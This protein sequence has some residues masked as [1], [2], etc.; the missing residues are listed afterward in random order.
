[1][2]MNLTFE[3]AEDFA[4]TMRIPYDENMPGTAWLAI[5]QNLDGL[6]FKS[7]RS[8][9]PELLSSITFH[10]VD[11]MFDLISNYIDDSGLPDAKINAFHEANEIGDT[12][13]LFDN[14]DYVIELY[15][16]HVSDEVYGFAHGFDY[17]YFQE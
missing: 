2:I 5:E 13:W 10:N 9:L 1:M 7:A 16:A 6:D 8:A 12:S 14:E 17:L 3:S 15:S 11:N 4:E